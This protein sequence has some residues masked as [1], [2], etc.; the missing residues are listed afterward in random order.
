M[1]LSEENPNKKIIDKLGKLKKL[2]K[3]PLIS[4]TIPAHNE[5]KYVWKAIESMLK[6][7]YKP[8]ELIV[9]NNGST[10]NTLE[11]INK[12]KDKIKIVNSKENLGF[13][14]GCNEGW[15]VSKGDILMF[16]DA[17]E[18][19]G[20][21]YLKNL[22]TPILE[23]KDVCTMHHMEKI[24]NFTNPWARA[25]GT[26]YTTQNGRGK[27]FTM[28]RRDVFEKLGPFD[29]SLGYADDKTLNIKHGLTSYGV[30]ADISHHNPDTLK[31]HWNHGKWV[32][33]SYKHPWITIFFLPLFPLYVLYKSVNQFIDD[34]YWKFIYFL[35]FYHTVKYFSYFAGAIQRLKG[36]KR[37]T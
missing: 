15:K 34:P 17:D 2:P 6:Q 18:I 36:E 13:G 37:T 32:G 5:E 28:I 24:A 14:G 29:P 4:V 12:Y 9:V 25:F 31:V 23:E 33:K 27:I 16:F 35:P 1:N 8:M 19:Y 26:R 30:D 3:K 21:D 10:D 7:T 22:V 20:E 11:V